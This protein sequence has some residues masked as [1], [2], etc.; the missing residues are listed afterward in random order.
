MRK[1]YVFILIVVMLL[2]ISFAPFAYSE[3]IVA[4]TEKESEYD[5]DLLKSEESINLF[6]TMQS[7]PFVENEYISVAI[8]EDSASYLYRFTAATVL[9]NPNNPLDDNKRLLY[10]YPNAGTSYTTIRINGAD[11][12][13]GSDGENLERNISDE[14]HSSVVRIGDL[15]IEQK[16]TLV[17]GLS[18]ARK[19]NFK[20]SY[21]VTNV[22]SSNNS[23]GLRVLLDTMLG[24]NDWAPF[25]IPGVGQVTKEIEFNSELPAY[26]Q[27]FD[28][29]SNPTVIAQGTILQGDD[30]LPDR[31]VFAN[32]SRLFNNAWSYT[33]NP[34]ND[35]GDS[36][37]AI[38]W[39]E[40]TI[41]P[42]QTLVF[43]TFYGL[44]E[45][46][47]DLRPPLA[48]RLTGPYSLESTGSEYI[49]N[50]FPVT[51]YLQNDSA[52]PA[53]DVGVM[54]NLPSGLT[55]NEGSN[56]VNLYTMQPGEE[57]EVTWFVRA[58]GLDQETTYTYSVDVGGSGLETKTLSRTVS[59]PALGQG[60]SIQIDMPNNITLNEKGWYQQSPF[61]VIV[62]IVNN[63]DK[64]ITNTMQVFLEIDDSSSLLHPAINVMDDP[65]EMFLGVTGL[66]AP[67]ETVSMPAE[68][69]GIKP[70]NATQVQFTAKAIPSS[71]ETLIAQRTLSIPTASVYPVIFIPGAFGSWPSGSSWTLD[72]ILKSYDPIM[73]QLESSGYELGRTLWDFP[74]NWMQSNTVTAQQL[75]SYINDILSAAETLRFMGH[76]YINP[77]KVV[78]VGHSM[79]GIVARTYIQSSYYN[80]NVAQLVT[81]GTP[82]QGAAKAYLAAEGLEFVPGDSYFFLY[83]NP[84]AQTFL[85]SMARK[86]GF[87]TTI[88]GRSIVTDRDLY[89]FV[90]QKV[91]SARQLFPTAGQEYLFDK[92]G[93]L[94]PFG[95][96]QNSFLNDLN[97]GVSSLGNRLGLNNVT[98]IA[99]NSDQ[100]D[101]F[102]HFTVKNSTYSYKWKY[103]EV[104]KRHYTAG[105]GTVTTESAN[106]NNI[107]PG[108]RVIQR[109]AAENGT[110][111]AHQK[112]TTGFQK[113]IIEEITGNWPARA[114][115]NQFYFS[116][117]KLLTSIKK[118]CDVDILVVDPL[119]RKVGYDSVTQSVYNEIPDAIYER[120]EFI[121]LPELIL[122][123]EEVTGDW[124]VIITDRGAGSDYTVTVEA[125]SLESADSWV[126]NQFQGNLN[127]GEATVETFSIVYDE[128]PDEFPAIY[129]QP[130]LN[131]ETNETEML[132]NSI[133]PFNFYLKDSQENIIHLSDVSLAIIDIQNNTVV[134]SMNLVKHPDGLYSADINGATLGFVPDHNYEVIAVH[135]LTYLDSHFLSVYNKPQVTQVIGGGTHS[136]ALMSDE[137]IMAWGN[138]SYGQLGLGNTTNQTLPVNV[139][140]VS[141]V[142]QVAASNNHTLILLNDGTVLAAGRNDFGQLGMGDFSDRNTFTQIPNLSNI[143]QVSVGA[144]HSLVLTED[145]FVYVWGYNGYGALGL[146]D[147][148]NRNTPT[149][150]FDLA[151][152]AQIV[153]GQQHSL[154]LTNS[155]TV[156][157]WGSNFHG[158]LGTGN[159]K[160]KLTPTLISNFNNVRK[161]TA[162]GYHSLA[163]MNNGTVMSWGRNTNGQLG[164]GNTTRRT[165][166]TAIPNLAGVVQLEAGVTHSM[167]LFDDG[168]IMTWGGNDDGQL[169]MGDTVQRNA[170]ALLQSLSNVKQI[171]SGDWHVFAL[172]QENISF[173]W[174]FNGQGR[175]GL[176]DIDTRLSPVQITTL[177]Q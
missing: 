126:L 74:Y 45:D 78:L 28:S 159:T 90:N 13:F 127:P 132:Y 164:L 103:G 35:I 89:N 166:P 23:L 149:L 48:A 155:G 52:V 125:L 41:S 152:I 43:S 114:N 163:L 25:R 84:L 40:R 4:G 27:A 135:G 81:V 112:M 49:P 123:P 80:N 26:W 150:N 59:V 140:G 64:Y 99:G 1:N 82:H 115:Y 109:V 171:S 73:K 160:D 75:G 158:Q 170:P 66:I 5:G 44:S 18:S 53:Y 76:H 120:H 22:G 6:S 87:V 39:N 37:V 42:G 176:G 21:S 106:L 128:I 172:T 8:N 58:A 11:Y 3:P 72:P 104:T 95:V 33:A 117:S 60:L 161:L 130:P 141:D 136:F 131:T 175:L 97:N 12:K 9:G 116:T 65:I 32:W 151:D 124:Q 17:D 121:N 15:R 67:Y 147:K 50:P 98:A 145:G 69:F 174:G 36:A 91:P 148:T 162:G 83:L 146:G 156:Y 134:A 138:N 68:I 110:L 77:S 38:Y 96:Y 153:A 101:T 7:N 118:A 19:D 29:F 92:D 165:S 62:R 133:L 51:I 54:L 100:L 107:L 93:Q 57:K 10:G 105:D 111:P 169:G 56:F 157:S 154:A 173:S 47:E 79:G 139:E 102:S 34:S 168:S 86:H 143:K 142:K 20:V 55:L 177:S 31:V 71:G 129:W 61:D 30:T 167:A 24:S 113:T 119:G 85:S 70:S 2:N 16:I 46:T 122:I 144:F 63:T 108:V 94:N 88:A 137:S 14:T